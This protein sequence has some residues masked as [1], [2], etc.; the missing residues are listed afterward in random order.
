MSAVKRPRPIPV[1]WRSQPKI[2]TRS[3]SP[4]R[5]VKQFFIQRWFLLALAVVL[6]VGI[7]QHAAL[8]WLVET[9]TFRNGIVATVLFLMAF[10]LRAGAIWDTL[11]KPAAPL[12]AS[13]IN[14]LLLPLVAWGLVLLLALANLSGDMQIGL[15]VAFTTPSTLASASV[16]TRRAGG[17][18]AIT[19][20]VTIVTNAA[21]FIITPLWLQAMTGIDPTEATTQFQLV[22]MMKKLG[23]LVVLPM[24]VAQVLRLYQPVGAWATEHKTP[25][26][27]LAQFGV[28][29]MIF[30][31][32]IGTG[33]K[34]FENGF[35]PRAALEIPVAIAA[36]MSIHIGMFAVGILLA[37]RFAMPRK[38]QIA[39][40]FAGSQK[41]LMV[42]LHVAIDLGVSAIP[43]VAYHVGQLLVDTVI[44]DR[45]RNRL[46]AER[47]VEEKAK[48][49]E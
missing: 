5:I 30:L 24:T 10:P 7:S 3:L 21:C 38:D 33:A 26:G 4:A 1:V 40:G 34:L 29:S 13:G 37:R 42:G 14:Y 9:S 31:G 44:A 20:V 27:V 41:T 12:L 19:M 22:P 25:L 16:W 49:A 47:A 2:P 11:R 8:K 18:D 17:N 36:V 46:E 43:I 15:L 23:L 32:S 35:D 39:V 45:F 6:V 28:L 48:A